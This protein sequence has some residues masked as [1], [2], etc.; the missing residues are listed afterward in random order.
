MLTTPPQHST[1]GEQSGQTAAFQACCV[2][3]L[4]KVMDL[5]T[6]KAVGNNVQVVGC[7]IIR[8]ITESI[9]LDA[10]IR[11]QLVQQGAA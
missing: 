6:G 10:G 2:P 9:I 3:Y 7:G 1:D 5:Y 8:Y 11:S 4:V